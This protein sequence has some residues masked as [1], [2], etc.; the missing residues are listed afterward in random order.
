MRAKKPPSPLEKEVQKN[1]IIL[2]RSLGWAVH[3]RNVGI[4]KWKDKKGS[5]RMFRMN[6]A[7]MSDTWGM[8]PD[9]RRFELEFKRSG[10]RPSAEQL[11]WLKSQNG[12]HCVAFWVDNTETLSRVAIYLGAGHSVVY[13]E[14][15][16]YEVF[17]L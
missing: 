7:G 8:L 9:G 14:D 3:R 10:K 17:D 15:D 5:T 4:M 11:A 6:E 13:S 1:G 16:H 2:L 12:P